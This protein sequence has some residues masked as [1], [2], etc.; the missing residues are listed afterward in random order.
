MENHEIQE[1]KKFINKKGVIAVYY[2]MKV[3]K[4]KN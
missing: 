2:K 4:N 3:N 1:A